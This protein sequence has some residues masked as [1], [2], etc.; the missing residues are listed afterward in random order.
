VLKVS[1][2]AGQCHVGYQSCFY[3][4]LKPGSENELEFIAEKVYDP[5]EA[6]KSDK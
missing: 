1:V 6:Y 2:D 5:K 4:A 3:R